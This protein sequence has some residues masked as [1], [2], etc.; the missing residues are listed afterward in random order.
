MSEVLKGS[1]LKIPNGDIMAFYNQVKGISELYWKN[2]S[3]QDEIDE[4]NKRFRCTIRL[5][6]KVSPEKRQV[7]RENILNFV[8]NIILPKLPSDFQSTM[9]D[10]A[11]MSEEVETTS[12]PSDK[13]CREIEQEF[14]REGIQVC[15]QEWNSEINFIV[16]GSAPREYLNIK[17]SIVTKFP[18]AL[19]ASIQFKSK[20]A[21]EKI[22]E[23]PAKNL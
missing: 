15:C 21:A 10:I 13:L 2:Y 3:I 17:T 16:Y 11:C 6:G 19:M 1:W 18:N 7:I 8:Q 14:Q 9:E 4:M 23:V 20:F 5:K 22:Q 12:S